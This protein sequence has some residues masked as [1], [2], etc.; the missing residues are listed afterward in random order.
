METMPPNNGKFS[1]TYN[2]IKQQERVGRYIMLL[3]AFLR[4]LRYMIFI[5]PCQ[6]HA[7]NATTSISVVR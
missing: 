2:K 1:I 4:T 6:M 5:Y 3:N 7:L